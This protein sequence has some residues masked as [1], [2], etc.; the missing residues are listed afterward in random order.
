MQQRGALPGQTPFDQALG[1][2]Q[3]AGLQGHGRGPTEKDRFCEQVGGFHQ[4]G[5]DAV[6]GHPSREQAG[7]R[8]VPHQQRLPG[9]ADQGGRAPGP[10]AQLPVR[11]APYGLVGVR[12]Q[13]RGGPPGAGQIRMV[14]QLLVQRLTEKRG[15]TATAVRES[16][17]RSRW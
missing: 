5:P 10:L 4:Q 3:F 16:A 13:R 2:V 1:L 9:R 17:C 14:R 8:L 15:R 7:R 11:L 12:Q 6:H